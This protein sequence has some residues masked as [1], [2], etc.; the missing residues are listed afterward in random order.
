[1]GQRRR[2]QVG[3]D[4]PLD[5]GALPPP[6]TQG[7]VPIGVPEGYTTSRQGGEPSGFSAREG[8]DVRRK[9]LYYEGD[10]LGPAR[11]SPDRILDLQRQLIAAGLI[12]PGQ[13]LRLGLLD[14]VTIDA[15][16]RVLAT[17][18]R[19]GVNWISAL[20]RLM[21]ESRTPTGG[22]EGEM[23]EVDEYGRLTGIGPESQ[24]LPTRT[25]A[26]EDL[27]RVFRAVS[28]EELGQGLPDNEINAMIQ[29]YNAMEIQRQR[30]AFAA[31]GTS[32]NVV[33]PPSPE[34][35]A[36][37]YGLEHHPEQV[38]QE[39]FLGGMED[40]LGLIGSWNG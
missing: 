40:F 11:W 35:F 19:Y 37:S 17:A 32:S 9:P 21:G 31:E 10:E 36:E 13:R 3:D 25:T 28:I 20:D 27:R 38:E 4:D 14:E 24:Q 33:S 29:S 2:F 23:M 22:R 16:Y 7:P 5:V 26:P 18:N 1:M 39:N 6:P 15:Y 34:A 30:Q 12:S 8:Y